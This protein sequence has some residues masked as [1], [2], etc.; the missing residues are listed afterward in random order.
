MISAWHLFWII[1]VSAF[2]GFIGAALM[3][4]SGT[5]EGGYNQRG[6]D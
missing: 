6:K 3:A 2:I 4:A 5:G 1:P